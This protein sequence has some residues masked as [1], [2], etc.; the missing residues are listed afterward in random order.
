MQRLTERWSLPRRHGTADVGLLIA[1]SIGIIAAVILPLMLACAPSTR[2]NYDEQAF[3]LPT[4][5]NILAHWPQVDMQHDLQTAT[6]PGYHY[7]LA[8]AQRL[9]SVSDRNLR[10]V[11]IGVSWLVGW[12]L[13]RHLSRSM[14]RMAAAMATLPL[15]LNSYFIRNGAFV[16]TENA[17]LLATVLSLNRLLTL[18]TDAFS[19]LLAG[20]YAALAVLVR[21]NCIWLVT[22]IVT[23]AAM[24]RWPVSSPIRHRVWGAAAVA[25]ALPVLVLAWLFGSWH[26][27]TP[28]A[29]QS[30]HVGLNFVAIY[31]GLSLLGLAAVCYL[32]ACN[33]EVVRSTFTDVRTWSVAIVVGLSAL[34]FDSAPDVTAG[35][36]GGG[37][38]QV[39]AWTPIWHGRALIFSML[40]A[41]AVLT[42]SIPLR[43]LWSLGHRRY[44]L[45][46]TVLVT[47]WLVAN[48][49]NLF[50]FQRYFEP[51]VVLLVAYLFAL[52]MTTIDR[53]TKL[54]LAGWCA[55]NLVASL[56][57]VASS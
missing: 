12:L 52:L 29:F 40:S 24:E 14:A 30:R 9:L 8:S 45:L 22:G 43:E 10:L 57:T 42:L 32:P 15:L 5:K 49:A 3:H 44:V 26:G 4:I 1:V 31:Y 55:V 28:P 25:I 46:W 33:V 21:Q 16:A 39:A 18:R 47:S 19:L 11:N 54:G 23:L 34:L 35:R 41:L 38:W 51:T 27:L 7:L 2:F 48:I 20:I 36:W 17:A 56:W 13:W 37:L 53:R 50:V 6:S